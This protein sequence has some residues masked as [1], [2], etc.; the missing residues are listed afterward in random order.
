MCGILPTYELNP[1]GLNGRDSKFRNSNK[2]EWEKQIYRYIENIIQGIGDQQQVLSLLKAGRDFCLL[3]TKQMMVLCLGVIMRD[4]VKGSTHRQLMTKN[5][6]TATPVYKVGKNHSF[7]LNFRVFHW[8]WSDMYYLLNGIIFPFPKRINF[9]ILTSYPEKPE[10]SIIPNLYS[11]RN[12]W[13]KMLREI[14]VFYHLMECQ[15]F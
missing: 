8:L 15:R 11:S 7:P 12:R 10:M 2:C 1:Q 4:K 3:V 6:W 14:F 13:Y 5:S 9:F